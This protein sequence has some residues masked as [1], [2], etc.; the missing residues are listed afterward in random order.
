MRRAG[1]GHSL[2][3]QTQWRR[4][5]VPCTSSTPSK[6]ATL[7]GHFRPEDV[8]CGIRQDLGNTNFSI[9]LPRESFDRHATAQ[10]VLRAVRSLGVDATVNDRN[11][12]CVGGNKI[13]PIEPP[14]R[15]V[16]LILPQCSRLRFRV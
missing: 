16:D 2:R 3:S 14:L 11:D 7:P 1:E 6:P 4:H 13:C 5:R 8:S 9:H 15:L 12:V 10:V